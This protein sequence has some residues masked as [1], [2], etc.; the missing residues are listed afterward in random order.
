M[1]TSGFELLNRFLGYMRDVV[2]Q[3]K[4]I[5]GRILSINFLNI[6]KTAIPVLGSKVIG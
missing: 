1:F 3:C 4:L 6:Y 2:N 5:I